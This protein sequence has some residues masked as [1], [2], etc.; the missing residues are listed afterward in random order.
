MEVSSNLDYLKLNLCHASPSELEEWK[1]SEAFPEEVQ[2]RIRDLLLDLS[3][4]VEKIDHEISKIRTVLSELMT[5]RTKEGAHRVILRSAISPVKKLPAEILGEVFK[6]CCGNKSIMVPPQINT[7]PWTLAHVCSRWRQVLWGT[8]EI[9]KCI[10]VQK[11]RPRFALPDNRAIPTV[12]D[13]IISRTKA[14][15]ALKLP[16]GLN[17]PIVDIILRSPERFTKLDLEI[18]YH[19]FS[20]LLNAPISSFLALETLNISLRCNVAPT[21]PSCQSTPFQT[22][23]HLR[24]VMFDTGNY[25]YHLP[26]LLLLPWSQLTDVRIL[27]MKITPSVIHS[28]FQKCISLTTVKLMVGV[29]SENSTFTPSHITLLNLK[30]MTLSCHRHDIVQWND[31]FHPLILP[32][33][34]RFSLHTPSSSWCQDGFISLIERSACTPIYLSV[35]DGSTRPHYLGLGDTYTLLRALPFLEE[36]RTSF[37][38]LPSTFKAMMQDNLASNL[39]HIKCRVH[40]DGLEAFVDLMQHYNGSVV[41]DGMVS[42]SIRSFGRMDTENS[43]SRLNDALSGCTDAGRNFNISFI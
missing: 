34:E 26:H 23:P 29:E 43:A 22:A 42:A 15:V 11:I 33:L 18:D 32:C 3:H 14:H 21:P 13:H 1:S 17:G 2:N 40:H 20:K 25:D 6:R 7:P 27:H 38:V 24:Q 16:N 35:M 37:V 39:L 31:F 28:I 9:W 10:Q 4:N 36:F 30:S 41:F 19:S 5:Q 8:S 12:V